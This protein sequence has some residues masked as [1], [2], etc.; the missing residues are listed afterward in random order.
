MQNN[1][2]SELEINLIVRMSK[3]ICNITD[4]KL[5]TNSDIDDALN[6]I[7]TSNSKYDICSSLDSLYYCYSIMLSEVRSIKRQVV[8]G[9][10]Q[11]KPKLMDE[12][13]VLEKKLD[14]IPE[15][16][17]YKQYEEYIWQFLEHITNIK[18]NINWLIKEEENT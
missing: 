4:S 2:L 6:L 18:N 12:K 13:S 17:K 7:E 11:D 3:L 9:I 10:F 1:F 15:Y 5:V 16:A 14:A 8:T